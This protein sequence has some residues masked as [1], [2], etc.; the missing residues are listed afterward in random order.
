VFGKLA[1]G[2]R[3]IFMARILSVPGEVRCLPR[4]LFHC[5]AKTSAS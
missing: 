1:A 4:T 2:L 3:Q 5:Q